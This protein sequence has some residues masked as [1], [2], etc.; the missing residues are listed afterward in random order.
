MSSKKGLLVTCERCGAT[1]FREYIGKGETDGGYTTWD[2][3]EPASEGWAYILEVGTLCPAC[4][5]E[6]Q[7]FVEEFKAS[8]EECFYYRNDMPG[9][10]CCHPELSFRCGYKGSRKDCPKYESIKE[11]RKEK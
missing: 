10:D 2:K 7:R 3:F 1:E 4:N 5:K 9:H 6:Y 11:N 8:A